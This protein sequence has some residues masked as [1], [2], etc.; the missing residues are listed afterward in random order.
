MRLVYTSGTAKPNS[1]TRAVNAFKPAAAQAGFFSS[2]FSSFAGPTA[3][4][5]R[6]STPLP[7]P[8]SEEIDQLAINESSV[9][10]AIYS[11]D[12]DVKLEK[13]IALELHRSTKKNPPNNLRVDL[14]YVS[15][16]TEHEA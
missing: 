3:T 1:L 9:R 10:L 4:P 13:K 6:M 12:V 2:L 16:S 8:P 7:L 14:I 11:A 15:S 5:Q